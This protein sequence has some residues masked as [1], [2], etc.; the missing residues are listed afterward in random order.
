MVRGEH[1]WPEEVILLLKRF[2]L[3]AST[4][5][6]RLHSVGAEHMFVPAPSLATDAYAS[7]CDSLLSVTVTEHSWYQTFSAFGAGHAEYWT[8][9]AAYAFLEDIIEVVQFIASHVWGVFGVCVERLRDKTE[10]GKRLSVHLF[11][12]QTV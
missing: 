10:S 12:D 4:A 8:T 9:V 1:N 3:Q 5:P 11:G 2:C 7:G 6:K